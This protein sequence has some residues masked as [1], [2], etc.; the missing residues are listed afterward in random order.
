MLNKFLKS[1]SLVLLL[2][3]LVKPFWVLFVDRLVQEQVGNV[4]FGMFQTFT[5]ITIIFSIVLDPGLKNY[6]NTTLSSNRGLHQ[7]LTGEYL[8]LKFLLSLLFFGLVSAVGFSYQDYSQHLHLYLL[9]AANHLILS[10][11][12]FFRATLTALGYYQRDSIMSVFDKSVM[13]LLAIPLFFTQRFMAYQSIETFALIHTVGYSVSLLVCLLFLGKHVGQIK[14]RFNGRR[15]LHLLGKSLPYALF[16]GLMS[17]YIYADFIMIERIMPNGFEQA[18]LYR[19]AYRF[20]EAA[21]MFALLFGNLLLP[22]FSTISHNKSEITRMIKVVFKIFVMPAYFVSLLC[23]VYRHQLM[24]LVYHSDVEVVADS[25]GL[26][27]FDL[28][29]ISLFYLFGTALTALHKIRWLNIFAATGA[30]INIGLNALLIPKIGINGAVYAT[31]ATHGVV[32]LLQMFLTINIYNIK[33]SAAVMARLAVFMLLVV[34]M[35]YTAQYLKF[36]WI[37]QLLIMST[38]SFTFAL[39]LKVISVK[40]IV[41]LLKNKVDE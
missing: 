37:I 40:E 26:L 31:L 10:F 9:L 29:A 39:L 30:V 25:F 17:L 8:G 22:V 14:L 3:L 1:L 16:T 21:S 41:V 4:A 38:L 28:I 24:A 13:I 33:P 11:V 32:G 23:F 20:L 2:N 15:Y 5:S 35:F 12:M 34:F 6:Y 27:M 7:K 19:K 36:N 18:G